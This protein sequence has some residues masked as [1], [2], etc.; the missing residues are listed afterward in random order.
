MVVL[1][2]GNHETGGIP[3]SITASDVSIL[4]LYYILDGEM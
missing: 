4:Y 2:Y 1:G 3:Y